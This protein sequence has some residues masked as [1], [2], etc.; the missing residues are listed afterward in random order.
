MTVTSR[1]W[2]YREHNPNRGPDSNQNVNWVGDADEGWIVGANTTTIE[3]RAKI[4]GLV[5]GRRYDFR[6]VDITEGS[7]PS[8]RRV[9]RNLATRTPFRRPA[10]APT[11]VTAA[12][13]EPSGATAPCT[14]SWT[15][16]ATGG[17]ADSFTVQYRLSPQWGGGESWSDGPTLTAAEARTAGFTATVT[18]L[19]VGILYEFRVLANWDNPANNPIPPGIAPESLAT[20]TNAAVSTTAGAMV[21]SPIQVF[22]PPYAAESGR[23]TDGDR[24]FLPPVRSV[25]T[26]LDRIDVVLNRV[27]LLSQH[28]QYTGT[29]TWEYRV[30]G[31][32]SWTTIGDPTGTIEITGLSGT[33]HTVQVRKIGAEA[34]G[35]FNELDGGGIPVVYPTNNGQ[36]LIET[37]GISRET[38]TFGPGQEYQMRLSPEPGST[39]RLGWRVGLIELDVIGGGGGHG[40]GA[41][42]Y[43]GGAPSGAGR[44][45]GIYSTVY[46][47][48]LRFCAGGAGQSASGRS[49]AGAG[50][51]NV[52]SNTGGY[53]GG[54]GAVAGPYAAMGSGGGGG[55]ASVVHRTTD[56]GSQWIPMVLAGGAAGGAGASL[57]LDGVDGS[58]TAG[59][60]SPLQHN[61]SGQSATARTG[62]Y[63]R[64]PGPGGGGG[65]GAGDFGEA[66][67]AGTL[68]S[69]GS[70][71]INCG[72]LRK[73]TV[74]T[75]ANA[76]A[77]RRGAN[78]VTESGWT[79]EINSTTASTSEPGSITA[80]YLVVTNSTT[81]SAT[82]GNQIATYTRAD[83]TKWRYHR[84]TG[85]GTFTITS[86][87]TTARTRTIEYLIV[88]GGGA[89]G[90][91]RT[92]IGSPEEGGGSGGGGG[93][94]VLTGTIAD[95]PAGLGF[96][97]TVGAGGSPG[98]AGNNDGGAGGNSVFR[99]LTALGGGGGGAWRSPGTTGGSGGGAGGYGDRNVAGSR[100]NGSAGTAGQGNAGGATRIRGSVGRRR[101]GGG[102]GGA[103]AAGTNADPT[104][105]G[106]LNSGSR[107][108]AGGAGLAS[109][110]AGETVT[111]GSGG[112]GGA[113]DT[114][115]AE[116]G[117]G[118]SG[119]GT[120]GV[121]TANSDNTSVLSQS[122]PTAGTANT[123]GGGGGAAGLPHPDE[124]QGAAGGAGVVIIAYEFEEIID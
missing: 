112:G 77:A 30:D 102:G 38:D 100:T 78:Y 19:T 51:R 58:D 5:A 110:I 8:V 87:G 47:S 36:E 86:R 109:A 121:T 72:F 2:Q 105:A 115:L 50:G 107:G 95:L 81:M 23:V 13:G 61:G 94:G 93:G 43:T 26:K 92:V 21:M 52:L 22:Q 33:R 90:S 44:V 56:Q 46:G 80:S 66:G 117:T 97:V 83:G 24:T 122:A 49:S 69:T 64:S 18:G 79:P 11:G 42:G 75:Y 111:Y 113:Y 20:G 3:T 82:G 12:A 60:H 106:N 104:T 114:T 15:P 1:Q 7:P 71:Q 88:G 35:T 14:V 17:P 85:D 63:D 37:I 25:V 29:W 124:T 96:A 119:G 73:C 59:G 53:S 40:A 9:T 103:T 65:S 48:W 45:K 62:R 16:A 6:V 74:V 118:G 123:G 55:A 34:A 41:V 99:D 31:A 68:T 70:S 108:G 32:A 98:A 120:G 101:A 28:G 91:S 27:C 4:T 89:G 54:A 57:T 10:A 84:F 67:L 76:G 116:A 39:D